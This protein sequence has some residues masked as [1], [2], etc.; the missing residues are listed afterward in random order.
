MVNI[1]L[2]ILSFNKEWSQM[3]SGGKKRFLECPQRMVVCKLVGVEECS[4]SSNS[5][6]FLIIEVNSF[7]EAELCGWRVLLHRNAGVSDQRRAVCHWLVSL[8]QQCHG[9]LWAYFACFCLTADMLLYKRVHGFL[10]LQD[11]H[12]C[13]SSWGHWKLHILVSSLAKTCH[14]FFCFKNNTF[15]FKIHWI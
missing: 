3:R 7:R 12:T 5:G 10:V 9:G 4:A 8:S 1:Y 6:I 14:G 13:L 15:I 11:F 2:H